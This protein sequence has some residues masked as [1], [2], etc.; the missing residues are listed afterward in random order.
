MQVLLVKIS[1][2]NSINITL[3]SRNIIIGAQIWK[4]NIKGTLRRQSRLQKNING[5]LRR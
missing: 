5:I 4:N 1:F 3:I 2:R